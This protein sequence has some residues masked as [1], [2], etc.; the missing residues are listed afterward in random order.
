MRKEYEPKGVKFLAL[1]IE[2]DPIL[3]E[4]GIDQYGI[5]MPVA[6]R[7]GETLGPLAVNQ[8]PSTIWVNEEGVIVAAGKGEKSRSFFEKRTRGL[9]SE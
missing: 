4:R 8:V 1:S 9:L 6:I 5:S 2:P 3:V 7:E